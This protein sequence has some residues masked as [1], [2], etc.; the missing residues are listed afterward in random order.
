MNSQRLAAF[1]GLNR[2]KPD[3][4]SDE[5]GNKLVPSFLTQN[6]LQ[7]TITCEQKKFFVYHWVYKSYLR[8]CPTPSSKWLTGNEISGILFLF[9]CFCFLF[10]FWFHNALSGHFFLPYK[11][12]ACWVFFCVWG[13]PFAVFLWDFP[14]FLSFSVLLSLSLC[15]CVCFL[16]PLL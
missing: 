10:V 3:G 15:V 7:L 12:L 4:P 6:F 9:F 11:S 5:S 14:L 2:S 1:T 13:I 8:R 16:C